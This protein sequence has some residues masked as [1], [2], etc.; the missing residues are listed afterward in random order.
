MK[1]NKDVLEWLKNAESEG[2]MNPFA[3][4]VV[5]WIEENQNQDLSQFLANLDICCYSTKY[6]EDI[7]CIYFQNASA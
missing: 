1:E 7:I 6:N 4:N 2:Q 5:A 3:E